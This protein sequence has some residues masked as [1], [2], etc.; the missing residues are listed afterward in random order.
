[1]VQDVAD[2]ETPGRSRVGWYVAVKPKGRLP[3]L[4]HFRMPFEILPS[5]PEVARPPRSVKL[6]LVRSSF[7]VDRPCVRDDSYCRHRGAYIIKHSSPHRVDSN[8][9]S[10]SG[11]SSSTFDLWLGSLWLGDSTSTTSPAMEAQ[12]S[13]SSGAGPE[14]LS[15]TKGSAVVEPDLGDQQA[16]SASPGTETSERAGTESSERAGPDVGPD[17]DA[18]YSDEESDTSSVAA[19]KRRD[20]LIAG[21][22]TIH[23]KV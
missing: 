15:T 8:S 20:V 23:P 3:G 7:W 16:R 13:L 11:R 14:S 22:F 10:T 19:D 6:R 5:L 2:S 12:I 4:L 1:M 17:D 18:T 21:L 9:S